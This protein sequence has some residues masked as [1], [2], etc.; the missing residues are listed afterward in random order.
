MSKLTIEDIHQSNSPQGV[1]E[2][3]QKLGY[4]VALRQV[5]L[6]DLELPERHT[7]QIE[8]VY[9][10][11]EYQQGTQ[12]FQILLFQQRRDYHKF[13]V[14]A[15]WLRAIANNLLNRPAHYLFIVARDYRQL[16]LCSPS[17]RL[18]DNFNLALSWESCYVDRVEPS[19]RDRHCLEKL[20]FQHTAPRLLQVA[21]AAALKA[22]ENPEASSPKVPVDSV[23][24]YLNEIGR[25]PMLTAQEEIEI[26][27]QL[28]P[29]DVA[30]RNRLVA[31]NMRL[32]VLIAKRYQGRGLELLD[33]I[34]SGNLGLIRAAEKFDSERGFR[35][36]TYATW[37]IRQGITR[38]IA[39]ES[40][41]IRLPVHLNDKLSEVKQVAKEL[42][43]E[44]HRTPTHPEIADRLAIDVTK[45]QYFLQL[46]KPTCS[47]DLS[48]GS[49]LATALLDLLSSP[50]LS[51]FDAIEQES[52]A[53]E[54]AIVLETLTP[55]EAEVLKWRYGFDD[56]GAKSL[57]EIGQNYG[58]SR[59]RI[60]QIED[61]ALKKLNNPK[62]RKTLQDLLF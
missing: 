60:R 62:R 58:L 4:P 51:N 12:S 18:D 23:R 35:F 27:R 13:S 25:I 20:K 24:A 56:N 16:F 47:L 45:L 43:Q 38:A 39:D 6:L 9:F 55:R 53:A 1:A 3:L 36:S 29:A 34:Q 28:D 21:H 19:S 46:F 41:T 40:R 49:D 48:V 61:G 30:A 54:I 2:L 33:L 26:A 37:W 11:S 50:N 10:L 32:V 8:A 15:D 42:T 57:A 7:S 59:E 22:A 14:S 52:I 17:K 44:L 31:A 5:D